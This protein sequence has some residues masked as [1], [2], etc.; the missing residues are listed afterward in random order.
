MRPA[1]LW[2]I[3]LLLPSARFRPSAAAVAGGT[4][5]S[6]SSPEEAAQK[7][8]VAAEAND[9]AALIRIFGA[10]GKPLIESGDAVQDKNQRAEFAR[11]ARRA[12]K[13]LPDPNDESRIFILTGE[14]QEPFAVPLVRK[15]G[16]WQFD[17]KAGLTELLARRIG[18]NELDAIKRMIG[19]IT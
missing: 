9:T 1:A 2:L 6:F 13:L 4:R 10:E 19:R 18:A 16:G 15:G 8:L 17:T 3:L 12:M 5:Q 11:T 7:F 14:E